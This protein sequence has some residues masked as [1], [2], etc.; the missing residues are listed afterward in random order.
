MEVL[1]R[2][3]NL[4]GSDIIYINR[5]T[6]NSYK[7]VFVALGIASIGIF[8]E[9]LYIKSDITTRYVVSLAKNPVLDYRSYLIEYIKHG[10]RFASVLL[11][12]F[13]IRELNDLIMSYIF[14]LLYIQTVG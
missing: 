13:E 12:I 10:D 1:D 2:I 7:Y 9:N 3:E 5:D 11:N 4:N 8:T 6:Y 14:P